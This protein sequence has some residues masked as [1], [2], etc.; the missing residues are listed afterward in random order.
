MRHLRR[1]D[2]PRDL[3]LVVQAGRFDKWKDPQGSELALGRSLAATARK[4]AI[5]A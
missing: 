2:I 3:P 5:I 4:P 1:Y